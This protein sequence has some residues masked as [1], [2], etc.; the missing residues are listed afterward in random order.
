MRYGQVMLTMGFTLLLTLMVG[1]AE[2]PSPEYVKAMKDLSGVMQALDHPGAAEDF[3]LGERS[4]A[5]AKQALAI[6]RKY[7]DAKVTT[8]AVKLAD[9]GIK[10]AID[11]GVA[12]S[13]SSAEGVEVAVKD[14]GAT[15]TACHKAHRDKLAD[16][17]FEIK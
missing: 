5:T 1:A 3:A 17:S 2:K 10:A 16:G 4:A 6:I 7:W 12:A 15:C 13:L 14:L 9:V 11:L 8:D